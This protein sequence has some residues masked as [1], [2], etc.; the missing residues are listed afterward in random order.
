MTPVS[1]YV[2]DGSRWRNEVATSRSTPQVAEAVAGVQRAP[3]GDVTTNGVAW[4][5]VF[6]E[7]F[8]SSTR[9]AVWHPYPDG[10]GQGKYNDGARVTYHDSC[11]DIEIAQVAGVMQG[12][13]G[14]F[15][16]GQNSMRTSMRFRTDAPFTGAG[17]AGMIWPRSG[18]WS[19]GEIDW[20][21]VQFNG[22]ITGFIHRVGLNPEQNALVVNTAVTP[23]SGWHTVV[24]E[25]RPGHYVRC[26][27]DGVLLGTCTSAV[28]V[29][30]HDWR[31]QAAANG[32][33]RSAGGHMLVDWIA[34]WVLA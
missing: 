19:E 22:N 6:V 4:R 33:T 20:P 32:G 29:N 28:A 15:G 2:F 12:T 17:C 1:Q 31:L 27:L 25:W 26:F 23:W 24:T 16:V 5:Q 14:I 8:D 34:Q 10:S 30:S 11:M 21:E 13:A 18:K 9:P 7:N 3:V